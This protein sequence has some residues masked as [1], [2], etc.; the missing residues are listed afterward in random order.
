VRDAIK[1]KVR[2][3]WLYP[4]LFCLLSA[5]VLGAGRQYIRHARE[6][7]LGN[8]LENLH[9]IADFK[10]EQVA[11]WRDVRMNIANTLVINPAVAQWLDLAVQEPGP[12]AVREEVL[13]WMQKMEGRFGYGDAALVADTGR[14]V[15]ALK[16]DVAVLPPA[17]GTALAAACQT[18]LPQLSDLYLTTNALPARMVLAV[19]FTTTT[20]AGP[21]LCSFRLLIRINPYEYLF[22]LLKTWP[23]PSASGEI[24]LLRRDQDEVLVLNEP[25]FREGAALQL[26]LPLQD[27][28]RPCAQA[29]LGQRDLVDGLDYRG[30]RVLAAMTAI[31]K[32]PWFLVV[33]QDR[34]EVLAETAG[35]VRLTWWVMLAGILGV[36]LLLGLVAFNVWAYTLRRETEWA[37]EFRQLFDHVGDVVLVKDTQGRILM[38]NSTA[39]ECYG[40]TQEEWRQ[41][42][43]ADLFVPE[44]RPRLP[45]L[46]QAV[47]DTGQVVFESVH[48][49]KAGARIP[50]EVN[51]RRTT[52]RGQPA[53]IG[54]I[55]DIT[56]R[57]QAAAEL[58]QQR[59]L[60]LSLINT[61]PDLIYIKDA[62]HRFLLANA[63]LARH[64]AVAASDDLR[65]RTDHDFFPAPVADKFTND[66]RAVMLSGQPL[67]AQEEQVVFP[68]GATEWLSTTKAP[69]R[70]PAG[71]VIGII[72]IGHDITT[73]RHLSD[74]LRAA[75]ERSVGLELAVNRSPAVVCLYQGGLDSPLEYVS[76]NVRRWGYRAGELCGQT[77]LPWI[78]P[79][80]RARVQADVR[81]QLAVRT[82]EFMLSYRLLTRTGEVRWVE[83]HT[84]VASDGAGALK[85]AQSLL[86]DVTEHRLLT[87]KLH[88]AQKLET[89]G[90]LAGGIA[91]DFNNLLQVILGF[92]ELLVG[93]LAVDEKHRR[94]VREIQ[95]AA[96]RARDLTNRLLAFSRKQMILPIVTD[97]NALILGERDVLKRVLGAAIEVQTALPPGLWP[98][99]VDQGQLRQ[100]LLNLAT[101]AREAMPQGGRL[102][103]ST[104]NLTFQEEDVRLHPDVRPGAFI[105]CALSDTGGGMST[106]VREHIFEPFFT[107]KPTG[108]G[109]GLGLAMAYGIIKQH[110]GWIHVY[111]QQGRG[112]TFKLY[113]PAIPSGVAVASPS[114][115]PS[116]LAGL[117]ILLLEDEDGVRNLA[118]RVL[119]KR[120]CAVFP[121]RI[122]AEA[123][124]LWRQEQGRFDVILSD[125]V[126]PDGNGLDFVGQCSAGGAKPVIILSSGYTDERARWPVIVQRG[127]HF[128]QKPYPIS[129]LVQLLTATAVGP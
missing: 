58:E 71:Q 19:P 34:Q 125:V 25:R 67:I 104:R 93:D 1:T 52:F 122:V 14:I 20:A 43:T 21:V 83:V 30:E 105:C 115:V 88:Q 102:T 84:R 8:A 29:V 4:A 56:A 69:L 27:S 59:Q 77:E 39:V 101:N 128:L 48:T 2:Y 12:G 92:A 47:E 24:L 90:R 31:P 10:A 123:E 26:R 65:N 63:S 82:P 78:H 51:V 53:D 75:Y 103:L 94:D 70:D 100:V 124:A 37:E 40:Y 57:R 32:S 85:Q 91:H 108:Q 68:N 64:L 80:D 13:A 76:D 72:G 23:V 111:S 42:K 16:P 110:D 62:Q 109:P 7:A 33:K 46:F 81:Q 50:V 9:H 120:E 55:R 6:A 66:E 45:G 41:I 60:L 95:T 61:L 49:S 97:F 38:A 127:Y 126:L 15:L 96:Q 35:M 3:W 44:E 54:V 74:K 36:G 89:I 98:V 121:A 11:R 113:L 118:C 106:E 117:R 119:R 17:V 73:F 5:A 28:A 129:E 99:K 107:T 87:E 114:A 112:T 86:I 22:K 18:G 116:R 79:D